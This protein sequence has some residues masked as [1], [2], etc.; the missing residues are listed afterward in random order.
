MIDGETQLVGLIGWPVAHSLSP[1]MQNA[2][3]DALGLNWRYVPLPVPP[4]RLEAAVRG[5]A[6]SGFRGVNVTVPHKQNAV[7]LIDTMASDAGRLGAVNTLVF[8]DRKRSGK[9][10]ISGHNTDHRGFIASLRR[11]GFD[12]GGKRAVVVGAGGGGRAVVF[13]LLEAD[14]EE[15]V[16]LDSASERAQALVGD[17]CAQES[18]RLCTRP[19]TQEVLL[20]SAHA[21]DLFVNATPVGMWPHTEDSIW[22]EE[23]SFPGDLTAFDLVYNPL[24]THLLRRAREA[25]ARAMDGLGMLVA[26]GALSFELW[27]G[28]T[29]PVKV[30]RAAGERALQERTRRERL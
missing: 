23:L 18:R 27:T 26:Q 7:P 20:E 14:S 30:M 28:E 4:D 15:I 17:L 22:P 5:L 19:L 10:V 6:A 25:G 11:G 24:E 21:A 1:V 16:V 13:G 29:A 2:A 9:A 8:D 12:P 3:F